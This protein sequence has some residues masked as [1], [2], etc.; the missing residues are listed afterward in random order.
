M[1][2]WEIFIWHPGAAL[3]VAFIFTVCFVTMLLVRGLPSWPLFFA[4]LAWILYAAWEFKAKEQRYNIRPDLIVI[5]PV[6]MAITIWALL[7]G[8]RKR[9]DK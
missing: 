3:F 8:F 4:A 1:S 5:C 9:R 6:M 7:S 2:G